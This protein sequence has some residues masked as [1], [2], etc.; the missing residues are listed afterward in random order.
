MKIDKYNYIM[1]TNKNIT[2]KKKKKKTL[3]CSLLSTH[4]IIL[5]LS[6]DSVKDV[7]FHP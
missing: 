4:K 1:I 2:D 6:L 5:A 3:T 7:Y